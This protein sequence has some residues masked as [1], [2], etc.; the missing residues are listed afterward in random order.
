M[1]L[2]TSIQVAACGYV[3]YICCMVL[4][5]MGKDTRSMVR[6]SYLALAA[7]AFAGIV[8]EPTISGM[9]YSCGVAVYLACEERTGHASE[10]KSLS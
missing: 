10:R 6:Y 7:G 4:N 5:R 9:F 2:M 3:L 8:C 1:L